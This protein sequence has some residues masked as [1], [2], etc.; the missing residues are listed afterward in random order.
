MNRIK[1]AQELVKLAKELVA[2]ST[3]GIT[4][5]VLPH[6]TTGDVNRGYYVGVRA[7]FNG[8]AVMNVSREWGK[9]YRVEDW[10]NWE[11]DP[12]E[13]FVAQLWVR[14]MDGNI[15]GSKV[16]SS[17]SEWTSGV[18]DFAASLLRAIVDKQLKKIQRDSGYD[19]EEAKEL[20]LSD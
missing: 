12:N 10:L 9:K 4:L 2:D 15:G 8:K 17:P 20:A 19:D 3:E 16:L 18:E 7:E 5:K 14:P 6:E 11:H 1:V 13:R